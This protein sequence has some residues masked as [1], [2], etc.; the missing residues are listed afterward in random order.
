MKRKIFF[1]AILL[2]LHIATFNE[3]DD[4]LLT[5]QFVAQ[6]S[7]LDPFTD[8]VYFPVFNVLFNIAMM[9]MF[10]STIFKKISEVFMLHTYIFNRGGQTVF[11]RALIKCVFQKILFILIAKSIIYIG[12]FLFTREFTVFFLYDLLSTFLTL[13]IFSFIFI[14]SKL[15]GIKNKI[16]LF[17]IISGYIIALILSQQIYFFAVLTIST[18]DWQSTLIPIIPIKIFLFLIFGVSINLNKKPDRIFLGESEND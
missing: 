14:L 7:S 4:L 17:C 10:I 16:S 18:V 5:F 3:T 12:F 9:V 11:K 15:F 2:L 13:G 1:V 6:G 8:E